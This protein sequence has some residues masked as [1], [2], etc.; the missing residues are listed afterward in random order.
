MHP[1]MCLIELHA[2][3]FL[4]CDNTS[5]ALTLVHSLYVLHNVGMRCYLS[6]YN[7]VH[8]LGEG[9]TKHM[10]FGLILPVGGGGGGGGGNTAK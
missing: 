2:S 9:R 3:T 6:Q 1:L 4:D 7:R 10:P 5:R 8:L